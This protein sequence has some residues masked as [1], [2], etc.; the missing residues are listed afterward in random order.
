MG[1]RS[2]FGP[3]GGQHFHDGSLHVGQVLL[4][5][6]QVGLGSDCHFAVVVLGFLPA[7]DGVAQIAQ[8]QSL[9]QAFQVTGDG[10]EQLSSEFLKPLEEGG[11]LD[12]EE[13]PVDEGGLPEDV[14]GDGE[15]QQ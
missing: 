14:G 2:E 4:I 6:A 9:S 13:R 3:V 7:H 11:G 10:Q 5:V 12:V 1:C 8:F 15:L